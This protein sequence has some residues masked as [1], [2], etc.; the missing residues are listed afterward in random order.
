MIHVRSDSIFCTSMLM[1]CPLEKTSLYRVAKNAS[2]SSPLFLV[3][4]A[5]R[6]GSTLSYTYSI[7]VPL[8]LGNLKTLKPP[9]AQLSEDYR[10]VCIKAFHSTQGTQKKKLEEAY[11]SGP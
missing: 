9:W 10:T 6:G 7:Y 4:S 1:L 2:N 5:F 8:C 11:R 3:L